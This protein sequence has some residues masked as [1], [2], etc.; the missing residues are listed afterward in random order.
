MQYLLSASFIFIFSSSIYAV[1]KGPTEEADNPS[2]ATASNTEKPKEDPKKKK[3]QSLSALQKEIQTLGKVSLECKEDSD[4]QALPI[5][6]KLC[7]GPKAFVIASKQSPNFVK[8][9]ALA[10]EHTIQ[11]KLFNKNHKKGM[12]GTCSVVVA[13]PLSCEV[14]VCQ[15]KRPSFNK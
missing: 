6:N 4:C 14:Q 11:S 9:K 2:L 8:I 7:G 13:P 15:P 1:T 5:G 3:A 10:K 12:F